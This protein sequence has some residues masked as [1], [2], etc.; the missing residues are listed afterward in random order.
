MI[1]LVAVVVGLAAGFLRALI[2]RHPYRVYE[3]K[4]P[5]LVLLA[6]IPQYFAIFNRSTRTAVSDRLASIMLV[7]SLV[8]LLAFSI[9]NIR[10]TSFLPIALGFFLNFLVMVLNGGFMP[11]NPATVQVLYPGQESAWTIGERLGYGK[12]IVL[13]PASMRLGILSD[14]FLLPQIGNLRVAF[15]VGDVFIAVGV[16]WLLWSLGGA[17]VE[18]KQEKSQ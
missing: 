16:I 10:K 1:L 2:G 14:R 13:E 4:W 15:S 9:L 6:F 3:L 18:Q 5:I 17:Q 12:D 11:I 7:G 8:I